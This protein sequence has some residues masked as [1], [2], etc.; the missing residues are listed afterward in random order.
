MTDPAESGLV[1]TVAPTLT[2]FYWLMKKYERL[3][4]EVEQLRAENE[5]L[6]A[7]ATTAADGQRLK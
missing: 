2:P 6:K 3:E 4:A 1:F 5:R 7:A